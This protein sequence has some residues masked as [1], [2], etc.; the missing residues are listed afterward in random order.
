MPERITRK[1]FLPLFEE[2]RKRFQKPKPPAD[3][4]KNAKGG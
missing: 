1:E 2:M 4:K 3:N